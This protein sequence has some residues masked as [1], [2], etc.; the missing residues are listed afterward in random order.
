MTIS[1]L[2]VKTFLAKY[3]VYCCQTQGPSS[4]GWK[5]DHWTYKQPSVYPQWTRPEHPEQGPVL[6]FIFM[7]NKEF[8]V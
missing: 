6:I 7:L 8:S 4:D 1:H 2:L 5:V 3:E